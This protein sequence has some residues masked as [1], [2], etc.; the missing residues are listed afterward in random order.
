MFVAAAATLGVAAGAGCGSQVALEDRPC[1]CSSD[2]VCC[3]SRNVCLA[4]GASC[5]AA[6]DAGGVGV[7]ADSPSSA[8]SASHLRLASAQSPRCMTTDADHV[9]WQNA[10]G[11][12]V[13]APKRGGEL[14]ISSFQTP[15]ANDPR[16]GIAVDG[17][18]VYS[19]WY[20]YGKLVRLSLSSHGAWSI[21]AEGSFFG[22]FKGPSSVA[23]DADS[24]YVTEYEGGVVSKISKTPS[25]APAQP[26]ATGL[27]RPHA[28]VVDEANV[29]FID[30]GDPDL[31]TVDDGGVDGG[32][33]GGVRR[34]GALLRVAK[35][36]GTVTTLVSPITSPESLALHQGRL[37]WTDASGNVSAIG[38]DGSN[39]VVLRDREFVPGPIAT[40]GVHLYWGSSRLRKMPIGGG[41]PVDL[42][43]SKGPPLAL[44]V[45]ATSIFYG[46]GDEVWVG[47]K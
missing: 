45:D 7:D 18:F 30:R 19:T 44:T 36:G 27:A 25:E 8:I 32:G 39:R 43:D 42:F 16:C 12:L 23:V 15:A 10:N 14:K 24:V 46:A 9:Y 34:P 28:V 5:P 1:P 29:Y 13:G 47:T 33:D 38:V 2:Y 6:N 31:G 20:Q 26:L 21:G 4:P 22:A 35:S 37:Y 17:G 40:D 41:K 3:A 11:L